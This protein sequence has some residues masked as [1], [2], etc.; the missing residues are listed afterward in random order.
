M[1]CT[2]SKTHPDVAKTPAEVEAARRAARDEEAAIAAEKE[3][4]E[5]AVVARREAE[6]KAKG[7][8][9]LPSAAA[10]AIDAMIAEHAPAGATALE[11]AR[12]IGAAGL[13]AETWDGGATW[14]FEGDKQRALPAALAAAEAAAKAAVEAQDLVAFGT[15]VP[16]SEAAAAY[17][18]ACAVTIGWLIAFTNEHDCWEWETWRVVRDIIKPATAATRCRYVELLDEGDVGE[19][20]LFVSHTWQASFVD[21]VAAIAHVATHEM[22]VWLDVWA[23][24]QWPG[25]GADIDFRPVVGEA[26]AFL[27]V[28]MHV[29]EVQ[30]MS[31]V[32]AM[33]HRAP[34]MALQ[35]CA[36]Y[37]VWCARRVGGG[38]RRRALTL[39]LTRAFGRR[40]SGVWS[41][42]RR[43]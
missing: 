11:R 38:W 31:V 32:D 1:G 43:R 39:P 13:W 37:R 7:A 9:E 23:V 12:A 22:F 3:R 29:Q 35:K 14:H 27:L 18:W 41:S 8:E 16:G 25:N 40:V 42:W 17:S 10:A 5:R 15:N 26:A 19:A 6:E 20:N 34:E 33:A 28:A 36:F 2:N 24:R 21:L 30:D 4:W